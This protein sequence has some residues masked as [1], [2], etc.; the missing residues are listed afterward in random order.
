MGAGGSSTFARTQQ[1]TWSVLTSK[2]HS[3]AVT[4]HRDPHGY[5]CK[6]CQA[7][8]FEG[9]GNMKVLETDKEAED[10]RD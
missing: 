5:L 2:D 8:H 6:G 9:E 1:I 4:L 10:H 3:V 7:R